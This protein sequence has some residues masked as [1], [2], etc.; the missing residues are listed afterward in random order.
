MKI[1]TASRWVVAACAAAALTTALPL[2]Q[3]PAPG[4]LRPADHHRWM[5]ELFTRKPGA[6]KQ[7]LARFIFPGSHDSGTYDLLEDAACDGCQSTSFLRD[8]VAACMEEVPFFAPYCEA[9]R[10]LIAGYAKDFA[11][12]QHLSVG[13]QLDAGARFLDLR[14]FRATSDD[15][16]RT[17]GRLQEGQF[18]AHHGL[19]GSNSEIILDDIA[20]FLNHA[21]NSREIV[22]LAFSQMKEGGGDMDTATVN[23]FFD[24]LR[25]KIPGKMARKQVSACADDPECTPTERFGQATTLGEFLGQGSQVIVTCSCTEAPDIWSPMDGATPY[26]VSTLVSDAPEGYPQADSEY[27]PWRN[28][29]ELFRLSN[30]LSALR[31]S[32]SQE[33]MFQLG[34]EIGLDIDGVNLYRWAVCRITEDIVTN[35]SMCGAVNDDW[36]ELKG[37]DAHAGWINPKAI[38]AIVG[39]RRDRVNVLTADHYV[40]AFTEEVFKL[41][42]GATRVFH[43]IDQVAQFNDALDDLSD[44]DYYPMFFYQATTPLLWATRAQR[45]NQ[46][47]DRR[48]IAPGWP[49]WQAYPNAAESA[50][51][52]LAI[53][54][55][56]PG[57]NDDDIAAI[58]PNA[59]ASKRGVL[60]DEVPIKA[61]VENA[62]GCVSLA[63]QLYTD[64]G[65]VSNST[66]LWFRRLACVW[67]WVPNDAGIDPR[68]LCNEEIPEMR[69]YGTRQLERDR[70]TGSFEFVV[71][72]SVPSLHPV[73]ASVTT[74]AG[75]AQPGTDFTPA[76]ETVNFQPGETRQMI[77]VYVH[78]DTTPEPDETFSVMLGSPKS[79]TIATGYATGTI[80]NDDL[81][82]ARIDGVSR[83]E[84]NSGQNAFAFT[85]TLNAPSNGRVTMRYA[86]TDGSAT[87]G[88]DYDAVTDGLLTIDAGQTSATAIVNVIGDHRIEGDETFLVTLSQPVNATIA[89]DGAVA[90]GVIVNDDAPASVT[91]PGPQSGNEGNNITFNLGLLADARPAGPWAITVKWGDATTETYSITTPGALS[92]AH[93]YA[94]SGSYTVTVTTTDADGG[95]SSPITF[96]VT[97]ANLDPKAVI[98]NSGPIDE[99]SRATISLSTPTDPSTVDVAKGFR[100]AFSCTNESL[101]AAT[102]ANSD[103][104]STTSCLFDDNGKRVVRARIIDKDGGY[105]EY[106]TTVTVGNVAPTASFSN[107]GP[108]AEGKTAIVTFAG[109][110]D[111]SA[112]DMKAGLR[113][114]YSCTNA[115]LN[116]ATYAMSS[117][118]P[119]TSCTF[120]DNGTYT[121]R[122]RVIDKDGGATE[123]TTVVTVTD[124]APS[125][126]GAPGQAGRE[127]ASIMFSLG[128]LVDPGSD[129]PW[130]ITVDWG[131][132]RVESYTAFAAGPLARRHVYADN[133]AYT[134]R[135]S[136]TDSD[137]IASS[138][139]SFVATIANVAPTV[140]ALGAVVAENG[141]ATVRGRILDPGVR[142]TFSVVV[143]WGDGTS[144]QHALAAGSSAYAVSHR[145]LDDNPTDTPHD[146]AP[147][148]VAVTDKDG[149]AGGSA[150][151]VAVKNVA[152]SVKSLVL[153]D[154]AG[155]TVGSGAFLALSGLPIDLR[156]AFSD[157][158]T[159]DTHTALVNWGDGTSSPGLV[160]GGAGTGA[161]EGTHTWT[162]VGKVRLRVSVTDDDTETGTRHATVVVVDAA[163]A[164]C[165]LA[166]HLAPMLDDVGLSS[167]AVKSLTTLLG[168]IDG[169]SH[170]RVV[171]GSPGGSGNGA[172][173]MFAKGNWVAALVKLDQAVET[174]EDLI[175]GGRLT[176]AQATLLRQVEARLVLAAKW[177]YLR[178]ERSATN[179]RKR[180]EAAEHAERAMRATAEGDHAG[181]MGS[182]LAAVRVLAPTS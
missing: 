103:V 141:V 22:V 39:L 32:H 19:A 41:N 158:G 171:G 7:S 11:A 93:T 2:A 35:L 34:F 160:T 119:T 26:M 179:P 174:I 73:T 155:A 178:L 140:T 126:T 63:S 72:L 129:G 12:A 95:A 131:D 68:S 122:G 145:Y 125:I 139:V 146:I 70:D 74:S 110:S 79:A 132:T 97:I 117:S 118:T 49:S 152:P 142:D 96:T 169:N 4:V 176:R 151:A 27:Y 159:L 87:A 105:A 94:D 23:A 14:F 75:T 130:T 173:G 115:S 5:D 33:E 182:W 147:V 77:K 3:D 86:T 167:R 38:P 20:R 149:G 144:S 65:N 61:C 109:A 46:I 36:D 71:T 116:R 124:V 47:P 170:A 108:I 40:P 52:S 8:P 101:A 1:T 106:T 13:G 114:A 104:R 128:T 45:Y 50:D 107:N 102:Y 91:P 60:I 157:V 31:D 21:T 69:V 137:R 59:D 24:R 181:A 161:A 82:T 80:V 162:A 123:Y 175:A 9:A 120:A 113:Y 148:M 88:S 51:V 76:T 133:G 89:A 57:I 55:A 168:K 138:A 134:V 42:L 156:A 25:E 6:L 180:A 58:V 54:D 44:P 150:T 111:P 177:T 135:V 166:K 17:L 127:G 100:Y 15:Q 90:T 99:G 154:E 163:G 66:R 29:A 153:T 84:G 165:A 172:C 10:D 18:Y 78:G 83:A 98:G 67:S 53:L 143:S 92:R 16:I 85:V 64:A 48:V 81:V 28:D 62:S 112:A 164:V 37:L 121:V 30:D 43:R 56:D 136:A